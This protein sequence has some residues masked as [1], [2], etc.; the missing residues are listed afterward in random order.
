MIW[1]SS[2]SWYNKQAYMFISGLA[3]IFVLNGTLGNNIDN[4][5]VFFIFKTEKILKFYS[6]VRPLYSHALLLFCF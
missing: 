2:S 1:L 4:N 3:H 5:Y 6:I